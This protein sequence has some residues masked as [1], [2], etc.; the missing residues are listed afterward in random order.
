MFEYVFMQ[1]G[2]MV[3]VFRSGY[4]LIGVT[5]VLR[6]LSIGDALSHTVSCRRCGRTYRRHQG[7]GCGAV[8]ACLAGRCVLRVRRRFK[9]Q[10]S[11]RLPLWLPASVLR[12]YFQ[13]LLPNSSS[14]NSFMFA[15]S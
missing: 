6:R 3:G 8:V 10:S 15:A 9:E 2:L 14:F 7:S 12:V 5:V 13:D 4:P 1:R 11:W